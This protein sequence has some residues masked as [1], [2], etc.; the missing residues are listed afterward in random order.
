MLETPAGHFRLLRYPARPRELLRAW[1]GA[2]LLLLEYAADQPVPVERT[3]VVNDEFGALSIPLHGCTAW[4]DSQLSVEAISRNNRH[5]GILTETS[6]IPA[7]EAPA[8]DYDLVLLR[9]PKQLSLL[10]YQL[11]VLREVLPAGTPVTCA[12][13]DK[14]LPRGVA[15]IIEQ[16]VG[17]TQRHRGQRKARLF[18][19]TIDKSCTASEPRYRRFFCPQLDCEIDAL[20]NVF[21]GEQLDGGSRLLLSQ[22]EQLPDAQHIVDLGCGSGVLG[23]AALQRQP[24]AKLH[25]IDESNLAIASARDNVSR[26]LPAAIAQCSFVQADGFRG[27]EGAPPELVLCNPPFHQQHVVDD[28]SGR[29]LLRQTH[30]ALA[31]GGELW[32]VAN[33]HLPYGKPLR[34]DFASVTRLIEN[35]KFIVW[36]AL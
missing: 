22:F 32:L 15:D 36:R 5:N 17:P 4:L 35:D 14:H 30:Q 9:I 2:D 21:S 13:M 8:E 33:R 6:I 12:G 7:S 24:T 29:R 19:A 27:Y 18:S 28:Y 26:I 31:A 20:P 11:Q 16:Y 23:L 34:R 25:F 1:N 3:L 10:R